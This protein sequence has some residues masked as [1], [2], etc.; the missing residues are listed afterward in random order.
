MAQD[1]KMD[2]SEV[3]ALFDHM[4]ELVDA[5]PGMEEESRKAVRARSA[6]NVIRFERYRKAQEKTLSQLQERLDA[7]VA[8]RQEALD[9]GDSEREES[10]R[11][12]ALELGNERGFLLGAVEGSRHEAKKALEESEFE[13]VEEAEAAT[14]P[15]EELT[16]LEAKLDEFQNDYATTLAACQQALDKEEAAEDGTEA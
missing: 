1:E 2:A 6:E 3:D 9:A 12:K 5:L 13:S 16:A 7:H 10:E 11:M 15:Q 4:Q 14:M 8:A